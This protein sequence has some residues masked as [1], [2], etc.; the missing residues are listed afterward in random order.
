MYHQEG[1]K[2]NSSRKVVLTYG[3]NRTFSKYA[4]TAYSGDV[5]LL[6]K[7]YRLLKDV[8]HHH[9]EGIMGHFAHMLKFGS[10]DSFG[11]QCMKTQENSSEDVDLLRG[12]TILIQEMPCHS[13]TTFRLNSL[14]S[15]ELITWD[16]SHHP[17]IAST[18]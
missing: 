14:M 1:T 8:T 5:Y 12:T 6:K 4:L 13:P 3:M 7:E 10:V 15:G 16:H 11:Q 9:M 17:R 2:G 18:F